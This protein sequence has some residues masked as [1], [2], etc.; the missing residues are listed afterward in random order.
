MIIY[1]RG[2][3]RMRRA[4]EKLAALGLAKYQEKEY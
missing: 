2:E 4:R 3:Q 1:I